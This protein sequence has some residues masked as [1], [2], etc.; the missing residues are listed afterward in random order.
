MSLAFFDLLIKP[1]L[2]IKAKKIESHCKSYLKGKV[3]DVG[4]GR[5][6]ISE[7]LKN[8]GLKVTCL[9]VKDLGRTGM[10][11]ITYNGKDF[12]FKNND[13]DSAIIA[14]VLHHCEDS[15]QVLSETIRVCKGNIIIFEDTKPSP[16]TNAMDFLSNRIRG[17]ETPFKFRTKKEWNSIFK[18]LNLKIID[19]QHD[20]EGEWFYPFVEHSMF[21]VHKK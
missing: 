3:L 4:A 16:L 8:S 14:Y 2:T 15:L 21:I 18:K 17:V 9:D 19:V 1:L 12:P 7:R 10:K 5:C 20:V 6:Y 13:F 11:V